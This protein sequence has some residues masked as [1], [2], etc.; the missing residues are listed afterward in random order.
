MNCLRKCKSCKCELRK[1][2]FEF[3]MKKHPLLIAM[4][5]Y[6][7]RYLLFRRTPSGWILIKTKERLLLNLLL[8]FKDYFKTDLVF[9]YNE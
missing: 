9:M 6:R 3:I 5:E 2:V 7:N 8:K 4:P 1:E